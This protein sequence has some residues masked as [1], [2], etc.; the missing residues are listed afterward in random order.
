MRK[1]SIMNFI[2]LSL[3]KL[4]ILLSMTIFYSMAGVAIVRIF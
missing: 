3:K 4:T 1:F 2:V